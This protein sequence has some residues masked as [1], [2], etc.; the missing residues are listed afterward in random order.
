MK[1]YLDRLVLLNN[2]TLHPPHSGHRSAP[3]YG[4]FFP[5]DTDAHHY[6]YSMSQPRG[7]V[8]EKPIPLSEIF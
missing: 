8:G 2:Q 6:F 7:K 4:L 1:D 3:K 5:A